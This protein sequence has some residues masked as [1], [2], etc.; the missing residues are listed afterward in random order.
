MTAEELVKGFQAIAPYL[1]AASLGG[2]IGGAVS[3]DRAKGALK[4]SFAFIVIL[5]HYN[6]LL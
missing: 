6:I 2:A 4:G 3:D 5:I 1:G